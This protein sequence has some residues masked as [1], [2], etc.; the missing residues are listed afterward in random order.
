MRYDRNYEYFTRNRDWYKLI[1]GV[2]YI[3]TET[4]PEEAVKAMDEYN[5]YTFP[6]W[7]KK[8]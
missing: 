3:P 1:Y 2:G 5:S 6:E 8:K 7:Y 4:A